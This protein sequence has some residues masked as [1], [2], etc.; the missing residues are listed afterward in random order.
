M[1]TEQRF[2]FKQQ[3]YP[4]DDADFPFSAEVRSV[5]KHT[6][7]TLLSCIE[8]P[9]KTFYDYFYPDSRFSHPL[10]VGDI[11]SRSTNYNSATAPRY[12]TNTEETWT[13]FSEN[14]AKFM[15]EMQELQ[16][17]GFTNDDSMTNGYE[18]Q[19][20][21]STIERSE[22]NNVQRNPQN[23]DTDLTES[24]LAAK[25]HINSFTTEVTKMGGCPQGPC[26][27]NCDEQTTNENTFTA[28]ELNWNEFHARAHC[29][30]DMDRVFPLVSSLDMNLTQYR[31]GPRI[32][33]HSFG[34]QNG[35]FLRR[36]KREVYQEEFGYD[37]DALEALEH[38]PASR[39]MFGVLETD[40]AV[41]LAMK[42][43]QIK[44][45]QE[46]S[47]PFLQYSRLF[48]DSLNPLG[49]PLPNASQFF[50]MAVWLRRCVNLG[51]WPLNMPHTLPF[52]DPSKF[53]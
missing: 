2:K 6:T 40:S 3:S 32:F 31:G 38:T 50:L 10:F 48:T 45:A 26:H 52:W 29:T 25:K 20:G 34:P 51:V 39:I 4:R 17:V 46:K 44:I 1:A 42:R 22:F 19:Y 7:N 14:D 27:D 41:Q 18:D 43:R 33:A 8:P 35:P 13:L 24:Q 16:L 15:T 30:L 37:R 49:P 47:H 11:A 53:N 9:F 36:Q 21:R 28:D 12:L 23:L 5:S